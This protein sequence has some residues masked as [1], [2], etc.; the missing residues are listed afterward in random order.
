M[1][2]IL[3]ETPFLNILKVTNTCL[4]GLYLT[5]KPSKQSRY[6]LQKNKPN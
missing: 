2:L 5:E 3:G 1:E 6:L 4:T